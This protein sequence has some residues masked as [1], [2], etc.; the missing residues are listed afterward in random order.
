[1][2]GD[3]PEHTAHHNI[4]FGHE[5]TRS[6]DELLHQ[7]TTMSDPSILISAPSLTDP[8]CAPVGRH[9]LYV[10]EPVPNLDG[11]VDWNTERGPARERLAARVAALGYPDVVEQE[12]LTDPL[13]WDALGMERGTPFAM[14][15]KFA[16]TGP[17]RAGN[18]DRRVPGLVLVGSGTVP[19]VGV[20]MVLLSGR[21]AAERAERMAGTRPRR[22]PGRS[23]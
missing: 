10:L 7:G 4:H 1:V 18:V 23:R 2:D 16:R 5:W 11:S 13:D 21:L 8:T 9:A 3:L 6:F 14:A 19:G 17:F 22:S 15:H 20:P 12:R